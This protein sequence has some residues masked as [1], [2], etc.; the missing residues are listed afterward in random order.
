LP[1]N[2]EQKIGELTGALQGLTTAFE[3]VENR[4]NDAQKHIAIL[5]TEIKGLKN[6]DKDI[7][8]DV[9]GYGKFWMDVLK[10]ILAVV[11]GVIIERV[12]KL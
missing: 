11:I 5:Q 8:G 4:V 10:M 12:T 3:K 7:K 6:Q 9:K 2:L 1:S